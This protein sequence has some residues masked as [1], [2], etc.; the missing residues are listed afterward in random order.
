[1]T[2][3]S[4][5]VTVVRRVRLLDPLGPKVKA[6]RAASLQPSGTGGRPGVDGV[7]RI[8]YRIPTGMCATCGCGLCPICLPPS[9][10][11]A[12]CTDC[13]QRAEDDHRRR[14]LRQR[15][16]VALRRAGFAIAREDGEPV[17]LH[18]G[19]L[20]LALP[21]SGAV[22]LAVGA[23]A[24][25]AYAQLHVGLT[26][27]A[28]GVLLAIPLGQTVRLLFGGV[29]LTAGATAATVAVLT[30]ALGRW[31]AGTGETLAGA[32]LAGLRERSEPYIG[33]G[34]A[35]LVLLALAALLAFSQAAGHRVA[36]R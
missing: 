8:H 20:R 22:A 19:P 11:V 24:L 13:R 26:V 16:A 6:M 30:V 28:A 14:E 15:D 25:V 35:P 1:M 9:G 5:A 29:S 31:F 2:G 27:L 18:G 12:I 3:A 36:A 32:P 33:S 4:Q 34:W 21:A 23:G 10:G 7:C 17:V